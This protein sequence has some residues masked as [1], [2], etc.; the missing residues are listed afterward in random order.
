MGRAYLAQLA[1]ADLTAH[2]RPH[3]VLAETL[4]HQ[5]APAVAWL[6]VYGRCSPSLR[7]SSR[8]NRSAT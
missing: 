6:L 3:R 4:R 1:D 7:A 2:P 5:L 8:A